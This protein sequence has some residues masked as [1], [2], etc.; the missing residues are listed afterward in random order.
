M[1]EACFVLFCIVF[2]LLN[3]GMFCIVFKLL[4]LG[5]FCNVIYCMV[6]YLGVLLSPLLYLLNGDVSWRLVE[7]SAVSTEW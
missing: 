1:M 5:M 4:N 6:M 7:P 2:E 3:L